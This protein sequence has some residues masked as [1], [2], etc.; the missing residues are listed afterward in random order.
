MISIRDTLYQTAEGTLDKLVRVKIFITN[1]RQLQKEYII[2]IYV[3]NDRRRDLSE[4]HS[5]II[6][7][8]NNLI[9]MLRE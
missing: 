7:V 5:F 2:K 9:I 6:S 8:I 4:K 3:L 1:I